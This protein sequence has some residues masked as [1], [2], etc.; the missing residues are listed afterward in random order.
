[1]TIFA[2]Y[3]GVHTIIDSTEQIQEIITCVL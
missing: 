2:R 1:V 3:L